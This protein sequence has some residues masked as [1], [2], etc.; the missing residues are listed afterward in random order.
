MIKYLLQKAGMLVLI[1]LG[2][3]FLS[4]CLTYL[5]PSDPA[6]IKLNKT[7]VAPTAELLEQTRE[8]MGL[9]RPMLIRY[10]DWL[11]DMLRGDMGESIRNGKPVVSELKKALP[12][13]VFLTVVSMTVVMLISIPLGIL[14][15]RFKN[16]ILDIIVRFVTYL[17]ASLPSFFLALVCLYVF[18]VKLGWFQ[19]IASKSKAGIV[20]PVMVL[21]L[22]LSAWY[23]RQ[24]RTI[25][26]EELSRGY[27]AGSRARGVPERQILFSH[28]LKNAMLPIMTLIGVSLAS[29]LGGTT[30]VENIFSWPGLGKL[31]M[32]A[33]SA[34]DYPVIQGYVV[35][36]ALIFLFVNF[37]VELS[38]GFIDPRVR[39]REEDGK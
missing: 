1:F 39:K 29:M 34:R 30:I 10:G 36:L 21:S 15:A 26:L 14:C 23:I 28:V 35:W 9:N 18:S 27:I 20:M 19:V 6:E 37:L 7:G 2:I 31:A 12:S 13:T 33:I 32:D 8:E 16:G 17:F 38:Y 25:V 22:S 3:T 24:V 11:F 5:S 4:F